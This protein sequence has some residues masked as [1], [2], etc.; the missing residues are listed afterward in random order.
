MPP[1]RRPVF[2]NLFKIRLPITG[3][4]S[5]LHRVSGVLLFLAIPFSIY[6]LDLSLSGPAGY[7]KAVEL[8]NKPWIALFTILVLWSLVHH[9]L[10]GIRFLF[11]DIDL[12]VDRLT[13]RRTAWTVV[14]SAVAIALLLAAWGWLK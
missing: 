8:F 13:A 5:F 14:V 7:G 9:L 12:G 2:L 1:A 10:A 3:I 11:I 4:T 6:A